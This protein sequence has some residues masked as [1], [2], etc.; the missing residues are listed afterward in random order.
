[1]GF[2]PE[3]DAEPW[4]RGWRVQ[5]SGPGQR[6]YVVPAGQGAGPKVVFVS[7]MGGCAAD[8]AWLQQ[9]LGSQI[10][11]VA[12]DRAGLGL[13]D[14][15]PTADSETATTE[16]GGL[17]DRITP[18]QPTVL[19]GLGYGGWIARQLAV[20][21]PDRVAGLVLIDVPPLV[22]DRGGAAARGLDRAAATLRRTLARVGVSGAI[23]PLTG[24]PIGLPQ[25]AA[26]ERRTILANP[27]HHAGILREA[28][29]WSERADILSALALPD[30]ELPVAVVATTRTGSPAH[31]AQILP[32]QRSRRGWISTAEGASLQDLLGPRRGQMTVEAIWHIRNLVH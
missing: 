20:T 21:R 12:Y 10:A 13:S 24:D 2:D 22:P 29:E 5:V 17:I 32:A 28:A 1:V 14:P 26:D 9:A 8:A 7:T 31:G 30:R 4:A 15:P 19:V 23:A 25:A 11:S 3:E 27:Q 18:T 16:L 6:L